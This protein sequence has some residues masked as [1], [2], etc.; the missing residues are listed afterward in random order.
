MGLQCMYIYVKP[1]TREG[2]SGSAGQETGAGDFF[3]FD[4][5]VRRTAR[6]RGARA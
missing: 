3:L 1:A 2:S 4:V 5:G 6:A